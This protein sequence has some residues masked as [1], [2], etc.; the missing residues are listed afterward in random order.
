MADFL[1]DT[2]REL[3]AFDTV[4][5]NSNVKAA[6]LVA[7][8]LERA[9]FK[10]AYQNIDIAGVA[11]ANL[12]AWAGPPVADG[13][14]ISGHIDTVPFEG[15]PGWTRDALKADIEGDRLYGRGTSDMK[16]FIAQCLDAA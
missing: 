10:T 2:I 7:D 5:S 12:L 16:G 14:I 6:Q 8:R 9:G 1:H 11:Q 4:S 13:L 15:Q 3:I